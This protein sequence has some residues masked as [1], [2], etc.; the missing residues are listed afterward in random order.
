[1]NQPV[2][3]YLIIGAGLAGVSATEGIREI[4]ERGSILLV[5]GEPHL[6]YDRPPLS[7]KLWLGKK[8]VED[9]YLHDRSHY[10][11]AGIELKL[12]EKALELDRSAKTVTT[13]QGRVYGYRKV[14]LTT[15]GQPR[16]LSLPGG[17]LAGICYYRRLDDFQN[18]RSQAAAGR[19]ALVV[20]GG[21]IGSEL[22][23][24]LN[25]NGVRV[26]MVFPESHLISRVFPDFLG[27]AIQE[28][29]R[30]RG[31]TVLAQDVPVSFEK[32]GNGF[33][34]RT[35][36]GKTIES[37]MVIVG[38]GIAPAVELARA[39]GLTVGDGIEVN[40]LLATSDA[41]IYSAGD[42]A[43]FP[44]GVLG[45]RIRVEHWD[46]AL[47]QGKHAGRNLA[48]AAKPYTH[49]PYFF[50]DLFDFGFEAVGDTDS[51]LETVAD[52]KK[53]N[54]TG[55]VYYLH[56]SRVRGVM[57]CNVWDKV[58]QA[59]ELIRRQEKIQPGRLRGTIA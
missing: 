16:R 4:D 8:K 29:Y 13:D 3:A 50:S 5:G 45:R 27:Q 30:Q 34:S 22:A 20:G 49:Q 40:S 23:A 35:R 37:D 55:V 11:Q 9:I 31:I 14:L 18:I 56:E 36:N 46:N 21:F 10:A 47:N 39:S 57:M 24:A 17:D 51:R 52:W 12:G 6:P 7:K 44:D 42:T 25:L 38:I 43:S 33:L 32:K 58:E 41:D 53:E 2:Y 15:G 48:G 59:R 28:N 1:M 19:T 26:T 54:E